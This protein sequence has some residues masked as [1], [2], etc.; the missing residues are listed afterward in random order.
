MLTFAPRREHAAAAALPRVVEFIFLFRAETGNEV[1]C[2]V[3]VSSMSGASLIDQYDYTPS[4][5]FLCVEQ[6]TR[7]VGH[8]G[9]SS[10]YQ[11]V[12]S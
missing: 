7:D 6:C 2:F 1:F 8:R 10:R 9:R 4:G 3:R 12:G 5:I 11:V